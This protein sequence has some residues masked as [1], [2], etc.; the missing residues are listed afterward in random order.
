M[1]E[2]ETRSAELL[3]QYWAELHADLAAT[4]PSELDPELALLARSL[5][6]HLR[7]PEPDPSFAAELQRRLQVQTS[8]T[9]PNGH[10]ARP[11]RRRPRFPIPA[12]R[13][14]LAA[15]AILAVA[16]LG[17][18]FSITRPKSVSAQEIVQKAAAAS[19][20]LSATGIR[21]FELTRESSFQVD[22][23]CDQPGTG[24][25]TGETRLE[26]Y[27][28]YEAPGKWR[29]ELHFTSAGGKP[30]D[31]SLTTV[32]DGQT[33]WSYD[34]STRTTRITAGKLD[35]MKQEWLA[36][37]GA[38]LA[39]VLKEAAAC[40]HPEVTGEE[41][42]AG[43][44]AYV[45]SLGAS[46][47]PSADAQILNGPETVWVDQETFFVLKQVILAGAGKP[48]VDQET[49]REIH[50]NPS[51]S[52]TL[53]SFAVPAGSQVQDERFTPT[54]TPAG[55]HAP[56]TSPTPANLAELRATSP[57]PVFI[58]TDLPPGLTPEPPT[59]GRITY[60]DQSGAMAL[61]VLNG[62]AGCCLATVS[63]RNVG[64][65]ERIVLP[66]G[67]LAHYLDL[68]PDVGGP[69]LWW[70][71]DGT[72]LAI[73][74][75]RL[76]KDGL[77]KIA[78]S[79][80]KTA[81]LGPTARPTTRPSPTALPTPTFPVLR[82]SWLPEKLTVREQVGSLGTGVAPEVTLTFD[83]RPNDKPHELLTLEERPASAGSGGVVDSQVT[84]ETIGGHAVAIVHRGQGC[85][86]ASWTQGGLS[87][88]LTNPYDPPGPPG[89]VRYSCDQLRRVI[90]SVH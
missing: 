45:V 37:D 85:V 17:A 4:P 35:G 42:V 75:P 6:D 84:H 36:P 79:M 44:R 65:Q 31:Q 70:N 67:S 11:S 73:S 20:D 5:E 57:Y 49:V 33:I 3:H 46:T 27:V 15:A 14:S 87:L 41:T 56:L 9:S 13:W 19:A 71:Q 54:P 89:A 80:S 83:P 30:A 78:A 53:F 2:H 90:G 64:E 76:T 55:A 68:S 63:P 10:V 26:E 8:P 25:C 29:I 34:S 21:G 22:A 88:T 16:L 23:Q 1:P 72:Y 28:W 7:P 18:A 58:P 69:I 39:A 12:V 48:V 60:H 43:R 38:D 40:H 32:A 82:P 86:S 47:C 59:G 74:G 62:P 77:L 61:T 66:N 24:T 52:D 50:Y 51:L 81:D